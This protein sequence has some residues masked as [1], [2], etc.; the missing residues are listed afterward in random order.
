MPIFEYQCDDCGTTTEVLVRPGE[1][2]DNCGACGSTN[3]RRLFSTFAIGKGSCSGAGLCERHLDGGPAECP[4]GR[5]CGI[6]D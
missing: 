6:G 1:S 5:C 2:V 3:V 4:P